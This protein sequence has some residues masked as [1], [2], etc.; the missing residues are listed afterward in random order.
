LILGIREAIQSR[1]AATLNAGAQQLKS[2][3]AQVGA[4]AAA[5]HAGEIERLTLEQ[6]LDDAAN[7]LE[8]LEESV[9]MACQFFEE[10]IRARAA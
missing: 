9:E 6:R 3:S 8:P 5:F 4:L 2:V 10:K 7:L 1:D